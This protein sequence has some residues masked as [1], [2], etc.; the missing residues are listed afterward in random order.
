MW[1]TNQ[2][3][4]LP[5]DKMNKNRVIETFVLA[6]VVLLKP[7]LTNAAPE[8]RI[9]KGYDNSLS[10]GTHSALFNISG[11]G[12]KVCFSS[13]ASNL[14]SDDTN[15]EQDTFVWTK[16]TNSTLAISR[17]DSGVQ[18]NGLS[19]HCAIS[20]NGRYVAFSTKANNIHPSLTSRGGVVVVDLQTGTRQATAVLTNPVGS[21]LNFK[22]L[23]ISDNGQ[24]ILYRAYSQFL[25]ATVEE[26]AYYKWQLYIFDRVAETDTLVSHSPDGALSNEFLENPTVYLSANGRYVYFT[27]TATNLTEPPQEYSS[28]PRYYIYDKTLNAITPQTEDF[29]VPTPDGSK[30]FKIISE[31][32]IYMRPKNKT[33]FKSIKKITLEARGPQSVSRSGRYLSFVN[34]LTA[35]IYDTKTK[36]F[37]NLQGDEH[38]YLARDG[39][40][41]VYQSYRSQQDQSYHN[42]LYFQTR[43]VVADK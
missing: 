20:F 24:F 38:A 2:N 6:A 42:D 27:S 8:I 5:E 25:E 39:K 32:G 41:V 28:T 15:A 10:N 36:S 29:G 7:E 11:D 4:L 37:K 21:Q 34:D 1:S 26:S 35:A 14:V 12:K 33:T 40:S 3:F 23:G 18:A 16:K 13:S 31:T 17:S 22:V 43:A 30:F 19:D 9:T